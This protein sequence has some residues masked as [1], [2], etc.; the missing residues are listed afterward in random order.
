MSRTKTDDLP[1]VEG[2]GVSAQKKNPKLESAITEWRDVVGKRQKLTEKEVAA[3]AEVDRLMHAD[4]LVRYL[5]EVDDEDVREVVLEETVK[6]RRPKKTDEDDDDDDGE[7][8]EE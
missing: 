4:G 6:Y 5:Y 3:K 8:G 1:G 2:E 7:G